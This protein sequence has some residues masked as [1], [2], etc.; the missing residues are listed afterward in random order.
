MKSS[1]FKKLTA[2]MISVML[3]LS[4]CVT[5]ISVSAEET[6]NYYLFGY[7]NGANYACEEDYSAFAECNNATIFGY[8]GSTAETYANEN[9]VP[10]SA[11]DN[12]SITGDINLELTYVNGVFTG[13]TTLDA[14]TY[15]FKIESNGTAYGFGSVFTDEMYN[16]IY[17]SEWKKATTFNVTGGEYTFSFNPATNGLTVKRKVV[18]ADNV[19][20]TGDINLTFAKSS[21]DAN[22]FTATADIAADT[23]QFKINAD[24]TE[25][26][27]GSTFTNNMY[28][29]PYDYN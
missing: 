27:C 24:G 23:Y 26:G 28:Y 12:A 19:K 13:K 10:F 14:G 17:R 11:L 2:L 16:I 3:V 5:G 8:I 20:L 21:N 1:T 15:N 25:Y 7:I 22:I 9:N 29:V 4:M 18:S 6:T